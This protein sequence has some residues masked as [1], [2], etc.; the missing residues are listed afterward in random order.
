MGLGRRSLE[1]GARSRGVLLMLLMRLALA[2]E[3]ERVSRAGYWNGY[4]YVHG[5][6]RSR[7][8]RAIPVERADDVV[9]DIGTGVGVE[10][11]TDR[12]EREIDRD[13][14]VIASCP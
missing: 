12:R 4:G 11:G 14:S 13:H 9:D 8:I 10:V 3:S 6:A 7:G 5:G 2:L 1:L